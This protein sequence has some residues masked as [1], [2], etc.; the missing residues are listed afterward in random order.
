MEMKTRF[1]S[2]L[3]LLLLAVFVFC[4][5]AQN[6][7]TQTAATTQFI[8]GITDATE[9]VTTSRSDP[10]EAVRDTG[11]EWIRYGLAAYDAGKEVPDMS[12][13]FSGIANNILELHSYLC[14]YDDLFVYDPENAVPIA[15]TFFDFVVRHYGVDALPDV[16]RR[17]EFRTAYLKS[18][19][20]DFDF[21]ALTELPELQ[22]M[23]RV[24][25]GLDCHSNSYYKYILQLN[26]ATYY[27]GDYTDLYWTYPSIVYF[28]NVAL[29][30]MIAYLNENGYSEWMNTGKHF[31]Y[32]MTLQRGSPS[33]TNGASHI[34]T[35]NDYTA[36]L[37]ESVH[38]MGINNAANI[39]L[40][41]GLCN[42]FGRAL[43]F[44]LYYDSMITWS[45][46]KNAEAGYFDE[47]AA[48]G[49]AYSQRMKREFE[50]YVERGGTFETP[51]SIDWQILYDL[52]AK[53]ELGM[54]TSTLGDTYKEVN[55][56]RECTGVGAEL[57]YNQATSLVLY[58]VSTRGLEKVMNAYRR[59]AITANLGKD[60][61]GLKAEWLEY[62]QQ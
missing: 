54:E 11:E 12:S 25:S 52:E 58:L 53:T 56:G 49:D 23:D 51:A 20:I 27:F 38:S 31:Y 24:M 39:W 1:T 57:T 6:T 46:L 43:G 28:K 7:G 8:E 30:K 50:E 10:F 37:H 5:C 21:T 16:E 62:L 40:S 4:S 18:I 60:Y 29:N 48:A 59:Q 41:E 45:E 22:E 42:Y 35:I 9:T 55:N 3:S 36:M 17:C 26:N 44:D 61:E 19:G 33:A 15:E 32:F 47:G 2:L 13:F 34:M 14:L